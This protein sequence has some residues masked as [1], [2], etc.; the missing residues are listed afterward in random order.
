MHALGQLLPHPSSVMAITVFAFGPVSMNVMS[1]MNRSSTSESSETTGRSIVPLLIAEPFLSGG[2]RSCVEEHRAVLRTRSGNETNRMTHGAGGSESGKAFRSSQRHGR[3]SS[4][5]RRLFGVGLRLLPPFRSAGG[6]RV[7]PSVS[8]ATRGRRMRETFLRQ[9]ARERGLLPYDRFSASYRASARAV[10]YPRLEIGERQWE[11]WLAGALKGLPHSKAQ[12]ALE[13]LFG[14]PANELFGCIGGDVDQPPIQM[15]SAPKTVVVDITSF[16][17]NTDSSTTPVS[18]SLREMM[19]AAQDESRQSAAEG[20]ASIGI[21]T[22]EQLEADV[23]GLARAYLS[24]S[25]VTLFPQIMSI[26]KQVI[27]RLRQ[28]KRPD[29]IRDLNFLAGIASSLLAEAAI[30]LGQTSMSI[31]HAR[32]AWTYASTINH[33]P[34]QVWA[35]SMMASSAYW[36]GQPYDAVK[37][38][39]RGEEHRPVGTSAARLQAVKA[40]AWS[41]LGD[42]DR[43]MAAIRAATE[44]RTGGQRD[45]DLQDAIGGVFDWDQIR[46]ERC[47]ATALLTVLQVR[48]EDLDP[49]LARR[50]TEKILAHAQ[51]ALSVNAAIP[52]ADRSPA[53]EA[54]I[55]IDRGTA[56]LLLGDL[57][58]AQQALAPVLDLAADQRTY[59]VLHRVRGLQAPL[60]RAAATSRAARDLGD[61][62]VAFAAGSTVRT[63]S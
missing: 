1:N 62:L 43:T 16:A 31:D 18:V 20:G 47:F 32:A 44:A 27:A 8:E 56:L 45:N 28:T 63:L 25:P 57:P 54:T 40:R 37:E 9:L 17:Q 29:Q 60:A 36:A 52:D 7:L 12:Q 48:H 21:A 42:V 59:P 46:E 39:G 15:V 22:L 58:S 23:I 11:R 61:A 10:G 34:L 38:I 2:Y 50:I 4:T 33:V 41:H 26:R 35:R 13:H 3:T 24:R 5:Y 19:M 14:M 51:Q 53:V 30:D 6:G 55:H 49:A